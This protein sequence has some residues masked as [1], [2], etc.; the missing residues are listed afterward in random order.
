MKRNLLTTIALIAVCLVVCTVP[1]AAQGPNAPTRS[2]SKMLYH[3]GPVRRFIQ[4]V[5]FI[6]YGCW[7]TPQCGPNDG[8]T[9]TMDLLEIFTSTIGNTP[10]LSINNA[11]TDASGQS[12]SSG[13]VYAGAIVDNTYR[14]GSDL[15]EADIAA[16]INDHIGDPGGQG[17]LPADPQG[18]Y[19]V[20]STADIASNATGF[21]TPGAPPFH[22]FYSLFGSPIPYIYL[23]NANRCRAAYQYPAPGGNTPNGNFAADV[24]ISGLAHALNATLTDPYRTAWYDRYGLENADKCSGMFGT[25]YTTANGALANVRLS[26]G[27]DYLIEEN[28]V[29]DRKGRCAMLP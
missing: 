9:A 22:S 11:Y 4:D 15:T 12:A 8:D 2:S 18:I 1:T 26:G 13:I 29:N 5:Y 21:C 16:I 20:V 28:W 17:D 14:H 19:V 24:M 10:Y 27:H 3:N 6:Y 7:Q 23:G 25:T